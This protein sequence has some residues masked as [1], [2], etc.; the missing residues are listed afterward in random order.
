[1]ATFRSYVWDPSLIIGQIL[2]MQSI[3]YAAECVLMT[4]WSFSFG[5]RPS[6]DYVFAP[7]T[8]RPMTVIQLVSA[9]CCAVALSYIVQRA[10]QCL[11][12]VCTLHFWHVISTSLYNGYLPTQLTWWLLQVLSATICTVLGEYLCM[13][14]E[15]LEIPLSVSSAT[16]RSKSDDE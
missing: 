7:Q 13:R 16:E 11:D 15:A 3:F 1:M 2:A 5:F 4:A 6:L 8:I 9:V 12:F 14:K 10:K